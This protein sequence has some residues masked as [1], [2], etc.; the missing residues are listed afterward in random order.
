MDPITLAAKQLHADIDTFW[1][2]HPGAPIAA[3]PRVLRL[4]AS[5]SERGELLKALRWLEWSPTNRRP[6]ILFEEAFEDEPRWLRALLAK[7]S[8]DCEA[9]RKGLV[10]DGMLPAPP[11]P[12][13]FAA[14]VLDAT[15]ARRYLDATAECVGNGPLE[16]LFIALVPK[17]VADPKVYRAT[18]AKL[19]APPSAPVLRLA[20][21]AIPGAELH[22]LLP[23]KA[24]FEVERA[25][26]FAFL[27]QISLK[28]SEGPALPKP[29]WSS[30]LP[31]R[32]DGETL[33][34]LL[35][36]AG[37]ALSEGKAKLAIHH[38]EAAQKLS[39]ENGLTAQ[40][41][42]SGIGRGNAQDAAGDEGA[43]F[44]TYEDAMQRALAA[45]LLPLAAQA[46]LGIAG[47]HFGKGR[48]TEAR[49]A[50]ETIALLTIDVPPLAEEAQRMQKHCRDLERVSGEEVPR[51]RSPKEIAIAH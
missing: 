2:P 47:I 19:T 7:T 3:G 24:R 46:L 13:R 28:P 32:Q 11:P 8:D 35:L 5:P 44:A 26:L 36:N 23:A 15:T 29:P 43:A 37:Q 22:L 25:G 41:C 12:A 31:S 20:V 21:L 10:D 50:Y 14:A 34:V 27:Q 49:M 30:A 33:R 1:N 39:G 17:R 9:V 6:V 18:L 38:F 4:V 16:G 42:A 45:G 48:F 40:E 51:S